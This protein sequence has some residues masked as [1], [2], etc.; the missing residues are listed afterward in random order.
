MRA[1]DDVSFDLPVGRSWGW[2]ANPGAAKVLRPFPSCVCCQNLPV[3]LKKDPSGLKISI[4]LKL[5][6]DDMHQIRGKRISMIFQEPMTSLNPVHRIGRQLLEV[7]ELHRPISGEKNRH[8]AAIV[9]LRKVGIPDARPDEGIP[10]SD[11]RRHAPAGDDCHG[12]G[13]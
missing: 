9:M 8:A 13:R 11:F 7:F 5:P 3:S 12:A 6:A 1:V 2:S 4:L 10:P